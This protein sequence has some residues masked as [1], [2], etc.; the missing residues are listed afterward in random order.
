MILRAPCKINLTLDIFD[1]SERID[2]YHN[3][4]SIVLPLN[5][6][7]DELRIRIEPTADQNSIKL[8][9]NH[10]DLPLD[11]LNLAYRAAEAYLTHI[12]ATY[13]IE[14]DLHKAIPME[15]GLGGGSSGAAAVLRGLNAYFKQIVEESALIKLASRLGVDVPL[16]LIDK[17]VRMRGFGE[18]I[19]LLD[20]D[21]PII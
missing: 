11:G 10:P 21:L 14:I 19:E 18:I 20:V 2:G 13:H 15:A 5:E 7:A 1:K 4:D 16:F 12:G 9:C 8:T 6:P 3:L 17:P